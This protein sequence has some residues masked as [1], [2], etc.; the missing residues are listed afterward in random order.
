MTL[1]DVYGQLPITVALLLEKT[2]NTTPIDGN[3]T[4]EKV[5]KQAELAVAKTKLQLTEAGVKD[6]E[7]FTLLD[8]FPRAAVDCLFV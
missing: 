8:C 1:S 7:I 3:I 4:E 6:A 2:L 5:L